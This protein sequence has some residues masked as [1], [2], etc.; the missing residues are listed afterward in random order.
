VIVK[1][2]LYEPGAWVAKPEDTKAKRQDGRERHE[3]EF[4]GLRLLG[5]TQTVTNASLQP[6]GYGDF[7][8]GIAQPPTYI[9]ALLCL[10]SARSAAP[11]MLDH[12]KIALCQQFIVDVRVE[13][14]LKLS[15][16]LLAKSCLSHKLSS[17]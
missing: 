13:P 3:E 4:P 8:N 11:E 1:S 2:Q 12:F 15:A 17:F 16:R 7:A 6:G 9:A 10:L 5:L 14:R